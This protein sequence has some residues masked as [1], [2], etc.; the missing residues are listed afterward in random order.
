MGPRTGLDDL[1]KIKFLTPQGLE[2][3]LPGCPDCTCAIPAS[4][5]GTQNN[6]KDLGQFLEFITCYRT[7]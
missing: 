1:E 6:L 4:N 3:Q 7:Y 2:L 5:N